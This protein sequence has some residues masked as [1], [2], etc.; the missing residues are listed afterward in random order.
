[1]KAL[2]FDT[3]TTGMVKWN[4][5]AEHPGQPDLVQLAMLLVERETWTIKAR[6]SLV[7]QLAEGVEIE[8][9]AEATHGISAADCEQY[10]VKPIVAVSLFNQ[11]CMQADVIVA[12]NLSF[13]QSIRANLR[14][15]EKPINPLSSVFTLGRLRNT[16][17]WIPFQLFKD[18]V[19]SFG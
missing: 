2:I 13:D 3:E 12:H 4:E 18:K 9:E 7:L 16:T 14:V 6:V 17:R 5:P 1:M 10:G 19:K 8:P 15:V 11:L